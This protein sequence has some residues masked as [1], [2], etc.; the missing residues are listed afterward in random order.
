MRKNVLVSLV[1][2]LD[3]FIG[4]EP[5]DHTGE[6]T[7][8]LEAELTRCVD[9]LVANVEGHNM[10]VRITELETEIQKL[11]TQLAEQKAQN[12][13]VPLNG[14]DGLVA[15]LKVSRQSPLWGKLVVRRVGNDEGWNTY[16]PSDVY[17]RN[18]EDCKDFL[19]RLMTRA[20]Q[21]GLRS[22]FDTD[23]LKIRVH[24]QD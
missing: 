11:Q 14:M 19:A 12:P 6:E 21:R 2:K 15:A 18:T 5:C 1:N 20:Q 8:L 9:I 7:S 16:F 17:H 24:A 4:G 22:W 3:S 23:H 10:K 13:N